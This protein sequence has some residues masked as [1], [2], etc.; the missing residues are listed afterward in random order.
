MSCDLSK[1]TDTCRGGVTTDAVD[2][3]TAA[4]AAAPDAASADPAAAAPRPTLFRIYHIV[5]LMLDPKN[6]LVLDEMSEM[7]CAEAWS[8]PRDLTPCHIKTHTPPQI[9]LLGFERTVWVM[10]FDVKLAEIR[11]LAENCH[12]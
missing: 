10:D 1:Q 7:L 8:L 3:D 5:L 9:F 4:P 12:V 6:F 11:Q 2:A